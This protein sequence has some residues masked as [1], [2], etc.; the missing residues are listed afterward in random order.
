MYGNSPHKNWTVG[1]SALKLAFLE[2][3]GKLTMD[4]IRRQRDAALSSGV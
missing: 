1:E 4:G 3:E 2:N